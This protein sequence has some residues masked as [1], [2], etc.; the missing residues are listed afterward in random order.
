M[1]TGP[2]ISTLPQ[3]EISA[4]HMTKAQLKLLRLKPGKAQRPVSRYWQGMGWVYLYDAAEAVSMRPYL[5][6]SGPQLAALAAGRRL[7][8]TILCKGCGERFYRE[9]LERGVCESCR[10]NAEL[11][12]VREV[13]RAWLALDPLFLDTET[14]GLGEVD[15]VAELAILDQAG[16]V[17]FHS[18]VRP[19]CPMSAG[20]AAVHGIEAAELAAAPT[21][22]EIAGAV[23][24]VLQGRTVITHNA[25]FDSRMLWQTCKAYALEAPV[26]SGWRCTMELLTSANGGHWPS[27]G[28]A[29]WLVGAEPSPGPG[30]RAAGD[31][32]SVR[33][34]VC[35]LAA[36]Q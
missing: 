31:A 33:R 15:Q 3:Q 12:S 4:G 6:P 28:A 17:L 32:E 13:A 1:K 24:A 16:A 9:D 36:A 14:T 26:L 35:T 20:A 27:L 30:H 29:M 10:R 2:D 8:G 18:L 22:P 11:G 34:I 7:V 23:N 5:A 25:D 21:W 19:S